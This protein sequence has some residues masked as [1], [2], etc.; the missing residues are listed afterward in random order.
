MRAAF[1]MREGLQ[2]Q[3]F[4]PQDLARLDRA[5][6]I[7]VT[8]T[9]TSFAGADLADCEILVTG[10]G[11][12]S[13]DEVVLEGLPALRAVV[14]AA[15]SVKH[16][17]HPAVWERG[18]TVTSAVAAN[19]R[20]VAEMTLALVLLAGKKAVPVAR[21]FARSQEFIDL[22]IAYP[23]I[24]NFRT[25]IGII[26]ASTIGRL[27]IEMLRGFDVFVDVFDPF[28]T[29]DDAARLGVRSRPLRELLTDADVVSV[30]APALPETHHLLGAAELALLRDGATVINTARGSLIDHDALLPQLR[31]GRL[32][33]MLD[34]TEPEPLPRGH[35]LF[36]LPNVLLTPHLA[37]A[38]GT[39][40]LRLGASATD[41]VVALAT[42]G[43]ARH[44][45]PA[46][47]LNS[48]A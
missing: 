12:P 5:V 13:I 15:G 26:G 25:R 7:D 4:A 28:L 35:E 1:A 14:H 9:V 39:E 47:S 32:D 46:S 41:E 31:S 6:E 20:P 40:L 18:I 19:A 2:F 42:G 16:H 23:T 48:I 44:P 8:Q 30:H 43:A 21:E 29:P 38:Q 36:R 22:P 3:L 27:V 37:G 45:V 10:W 34:V 24:G 17:L 33:A 11:C